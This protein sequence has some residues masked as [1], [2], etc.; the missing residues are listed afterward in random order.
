ME[1][2]RRVDSSQ[3][4]SVL[5]VGPVLYLRKCMSIQSTNDSNRNEC[6]LL[7]LMKFAWV[8]LGNSNAVDDPAETINVL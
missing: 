1:V 8:C 6:N 3:C 7:K 2:D 5:V 4:S